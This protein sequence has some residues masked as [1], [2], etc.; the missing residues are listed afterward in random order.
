MIDAQFPAYERVIPLGN[1]KRIEFEYTEAAHLGRRPLHRLTF[2]FTRLPGR[3]VPAGL[4]CSLTD[5]DDGY[6]EHHHDRPE[7]IHRF[8][9]DGGPQGACV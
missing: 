1:D 8:V 2:R 6:C 4:F 3:R 7:Q 5:Q 9:V